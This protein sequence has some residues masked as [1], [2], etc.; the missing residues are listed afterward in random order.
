[1]LSG[2]LRGALFDLLLSVAF[3]HFFVGLIDFPVDLSIRDDS[4]SF[5]LFS[6]SPS[7]GRYGV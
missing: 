1:M 6:E 3:L 5:S 7:A 2:R 4:S